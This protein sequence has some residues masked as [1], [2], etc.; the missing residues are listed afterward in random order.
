MSNKKQKKPPR[1][2]IPEG[3]SETDFS[4][5]INICQ[6]EI[7]T[8]FDAIDINKDGSITKAE[9]REA[10]SMTG[11]NPTDKEVDDWWA[12]AD[13][14]GDGVISLQEYVNLMSDKFVAVDIEQERMRTA[15]QVIDKNGDGKISL[16][17]FRAV[18]LFND[19]FTKDE[20]DQLFRKIDS[21]GKGYID[22][23]DFINNQLHEVVF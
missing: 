17:E 6:S 23:N 19:M 9:M 8:S 10:A 1:A 3:M 2:S 13:A 16:Q 22:Y 4:V 15:F 18:M 5:F 21:G 11:M 7:L 12:E 20:T 14:N